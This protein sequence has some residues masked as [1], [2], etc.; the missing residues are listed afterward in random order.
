MTFHRR[1]K[2]FHNL[3]MIKK[4]VLIIFIVIFDARQPREVRFQF[5]PAKNYLGRNLG[6]KTTKI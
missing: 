2:I 3:F 4:H 6:S 1:F 5:C